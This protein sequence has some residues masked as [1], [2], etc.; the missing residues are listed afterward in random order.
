MWNMKCMIILVITGATGTV[1]KGLKKKLE[2]I[3]RKTFNRFRTKDSYTSHK[4]RK[5]LQS[6]TGSLNVCDHRWLK[7]RSTRERRLMKRQR[8]DYDDNDDD[9]DDDK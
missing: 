1:T 3:N 9:D 6:E 8:N 2:A 7:R 4:I 5:V